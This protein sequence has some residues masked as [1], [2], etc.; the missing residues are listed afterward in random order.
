MIYRY[1][2]TFYGVFNLMKLIYFKIFL[3]L[4]LSILATNVSASNTSPQLKKCLDKANSDF[5]MR[6]CTNTELTRV[7]LIL[8]Q[9]WKKLQTNFQK[10]EFE[11]EENKKIY[12]QSL[13]S[14]QRQW[15]KY[16]DEKCGFESIFE[17]GVGS[18]S[19][20]MFMQCKIDETIKRTQELNSYIKNINK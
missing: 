16:V 14:F 20:L 10:T 5:A 18:M 11:S 13:L 8:N 6:E 15:I 19:R 9:T 2:Y 17:A 12:K 3:T 7:D 1:F 4:I